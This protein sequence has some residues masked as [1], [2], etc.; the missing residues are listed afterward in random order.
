MMKEIEA[1]Q[2]SDRFFAELPSGADVEGRFLA[3]S[4]ESSL[5]SGEHCVECQQLCGLDQC[6]PLGSKAFH[7]YRVETE[8]LGEDVLMAD[9]V[10][11]QSPVLIK[12]EV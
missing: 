9:L 12:A 10:A 3:E 8:S 2:L 11:F 1:F 6:H 5:Y 4:C 7:R